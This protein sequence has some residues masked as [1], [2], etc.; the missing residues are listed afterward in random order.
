MATHIDP[1]NNP[2]GLAASGAVNSPDIKDGK[3]TTRAVETVEQANEIIKFLKQ[4]NADR[5]KRNARIM[6]KYNDERPHNRAELE[7]EGLKWKSNFSSHPLST[8]IDRVAPRFRTALE[9]PKYLTASKLPDDAPNAAKKTEEFRREITET[10]RARPEWKNLVGEIAQENALFGYTCAGYTDEFRWFPL[11]FRQDNFFTHAESK[12]QSKSAQVIIFTENLLINELWNLIKDSEA[13]KSAGWEIENAEESVNNALPNNRRSQFSDRDRVHQ[14]LLREASFVSA[15]FAEGAKVITLDHLFVAEADGKISHWITDWNSRKL[16]FKRYDQ[17]DSFADLAVFF[18]FQQA[19]GSLHGSKGIGR[20][21]YEI[22]GI[23]DRSRNEVVDRLQLAGKLVIQGDDKAIRRFKASVVGP[24]L[25]IDSAM[26][27]SERKIDGN[28][29]VFF[30]LDQFMVQILDQVAGNISPKTVN[31][32]GEALRSKAAWELLASREEEGKD[33]VL[34]RFLSQCSDLISTMQKRMCNPHCSEQ[35][36]LEMQKRLLKVMSREELDQLAKQPSAEVVKDY[37]LAEQQQIILAA[38]E[39]RGNPLYN[40]K[41]IERQKLTAQV[42]ARFADAVLIADNDPTIKAEQ[43]RL[44]QFEILLIGSTGTAVP[45]SPRDNHRVHLD[46]LRAA[47]E[48]AL[49]KLADAPDQVGVLRA[50]ISHARE[51]VRFGAET[52]ENFT[53][54]AAFLE[55]VSKRLSAF[56]EH[57][58]A[59]KQALDQGLSPEEA[60]DLAAQQSSASMTAQTMQ[61]PAPTA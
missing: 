56:Q 17:F 44:Q 11:H 18:S 38:S 45:V 24:A 36:A 35:D 20:L 26:Q 43:T 29:E 50:I 5:N 33:Q 58:K 47:I 15:N 16:L 3:V 34:T 22:A 2:D 8:L 6:A 9:A 12:Q 40:Q 27:I 14:D 13:A 51:H 41:E 1:S 49:P 57:E 4:A 61:Q 23:I 59:N 7:A 39:G 30:Q 52:K 60:A 53:E 32:G 25:L 19:N 31:T 28:V 48:S 55:D 21:A 42:G 37:S 54:D 10:I 46:V